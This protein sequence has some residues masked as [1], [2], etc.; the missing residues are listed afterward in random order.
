MNNVFTFG[1]RLNF[2][3]SNKIN[4]ILKENGKFNLTV[5]N[6]CSVTNEAVK[7]IIS[8]IKKFHDR[9]PDIKIAVTGC[10]VET[11]HETFKKMKEVSF[12]INNKKKLLESSWKNL[13]VDNS[14]IRLHDKD[15]LSLIKT[16]PSNS[17]VRKFI[18]IQNGCDHSCTFCIIPK[19]RGKSVSDGTKEINRNIK[20]LLNSNIKEII[21]TGVDLTSWG[22]DFSKNLFLGDL[23]K[24]IFLKNSTCFRLR[25]SSLDAAELDS[26]FFQVLKKDERLMPHFHFSLQSLNNMVLKRM[27][28]RHSVEQVISLF[29]KIRDISPNASFGADIISGFPTETDEMFQETKKLIK[30]LEISH[31]HVFP[32]SEKK[33]TPASKMPQV[34]IHIRRKRAKELR[35]LGKNIYLKVLKKQIFTKQKVLIENNKGIGKTE[36]NFNVKLKNVSKGDIV[37]VIPSKIENNFLIA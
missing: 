11:N 22:L 30:K 26:S 13:S 37:E 32:Y 34:S 23:L 5:F 10:A 36:N 35:D 19:C 12:I 28:R 25:L 27:K 31:L 15:N 7:N 20:K 18:K 21:L 9:N 4:Q 33:G 1:C 8:N 6:T 16:N 3:E 14:K 24:D 29:K 17:S 2:W